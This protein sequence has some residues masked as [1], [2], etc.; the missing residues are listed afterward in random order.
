AIG[1][2]AFAGD[3]GLT[4]SLTIPA[5]VTTIGA[6]AFSGATGLTG[7]VTLAADVT[8]IGAQAFAS[9]PTLT[10]VSLLGSAPT[11]AA[12]A[13]AGSHAAATAHVSTYTDGWVVPGTIGGI[14]L[15][16]TDAG[17]TVRTP[18]SLSWWKAVTYGDGIFMAIG[19]S[20]AV[21]TSPDGVT[22]TT[23]TGPAWR[24]S[25]DGSIDVAYGNGRFV[26][27]SGD[28]WAVTTDHGDTW[29][30]GNRAMIDWGS[31]LTFG[32][33]RFVVVGRSGRFMTSTDGASWTLRADTGSLDIWN[34][35]V[36][37][38]NLFV[39][40]AY[41]H[42]A[43]SPDGIVWTIQSSSYLGQ[44]DSGSHI[45]YG[46]GNYLWAAQ[47]GILKWS[48]DGVN[49]TL[50]SPPA[51]R[52]MLPWGGSEYGNGV[53]TQIG[54]WVL[55]WHDMVASSRD[56][57]T[58]QEELGDSGNS[59]RDYSSGW[60]SLTFGEGRFVAVSTSGNVMTA[61]LP[62]TPTPDTAPV[63]PTVEMCSLADS[64]SLQACNQGWTTAIV[65]VTVATPVHNALSVVVTARP[66]G[67]TCTIT[68][69]SGSCF[70][71]A[72]ADDVAHTFT[73][74]GRNSSGDSPVSPASDP[75]TGHTLVQGGIKYVYVTP[76]SVAYVPSNGY[77]ADLPDH[78]VVP[79]TVTP[80]GGSPLT[81]RA[82]Q[83]SGFYGAPML[84]VVVEEGIAS[85]GF[86]TFADAAR[87][88]SVAL[89]DSVTFIGDN[90]YQRIPNLA[91]VSFGSGLTTARPTGDHIGIGFDRVPNL[92]DIYFRGNSPS[93]SGSS[94][95][96]TAP[97]ATIH[98]LRS[99]TGWGTVPGTYSTWP[100]DY[101]FA[102]P[103]V[104]PTA[105]VSPGTATVT[106]ASPVA[107]AASLTIMASDGVHSCGI[108]GASGT[109]TITG[110][111]DGTTYWFT[112]IA[113]NVAGERS[114]PSPGSSVATPYATSGT[115]PGTGVTWV[116]NG[117]VPETL[118][119]TGPTNLAR[120]NLSIP[121]TL[122]PTGANCPGGCVVTAIAAGAFTGATGLTGT[123][124]IPASV[125]SI[126][127]GAFDGAAGASAFRF[128]GVPPTLGAGAF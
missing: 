104:A 99:S 110:L 21:M 89:P 25:W 15:A 3:T 120:A 84:T 59:S 13:F 109:C 64:E 82:I 87:L 95:Y 5:G 58:W 29:S 49:W 50:R 22:W 33:G 119:I 126:G 100:I 70:L 65:K 74:V 2:G 32:N 101:T 117:T 123:V 125:A 60:S 11:A 122:T 72:L 26:V 8:T 63:K 108:S 112:T 76:G 75:I 118:T 79:A 19:P 36:Y 81:V 68:G 113:V 62:I 28:D 77:T 48:P 106:V 93:S 57:I 111:V 40:V 102:G 83:N 94:V 53:W 71:N 92:R 97:N 4:G 20:G 107:G 91:W 52:W 46:N 23:K 128:A 31:H 10:D 27:M 85:V 86:G 39:A 9:I 38:D 47:N 56:G 66:G 41:E 61:A 80:P 6:N 16:W 51:M 78:V 14:P 43:T 121:G 124:T 114:L 96:G 30:S 127:S 44:Y 88:R 98:V 54:Q 24:L 12:D 73:A 69:Q 42:V 35:V 67:A 90:L 103:T 34:D 55:N 1:A 45:S 116:V 37:G 105:V 115:D 17:W 18:A 7:A